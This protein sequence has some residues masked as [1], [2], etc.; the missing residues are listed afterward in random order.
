MPDSDV[1]TTGMPSAMA[2]INVFGIPSMSPSGATTLG[3]KFLHNT[4]TARRAGTVTTP[5]SPA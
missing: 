3:C 1:V 2:S 5:S 4:Y